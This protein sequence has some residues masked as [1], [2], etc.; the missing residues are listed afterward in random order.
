[1]FKRLLLCFVVA[2]A[3]QQ[4]FGQTIVSTTPE[5]QKVIL[6][7]FTGINC[8]FCP[9]G[10]AIAKAIQNNNPGN[11]FLINIHTGGFANP[12]AGQPDFR[13]P[14]GASIAGQSGLTGYPAGT[15]NRHYFPGQSQNG[16]TGTAMSR[17]QW[18]S[19]ANQT[20]ANA[21]YMNMAVE[22]DLDVVTNEITVHV[23]A[24]YTG[25]SPE[26]E[27]Q[28]NVALLQNNTFGPQ[29]G[30]NAGNEYEH[31]HR[32]V[33]MITGQWGEVVSPTTNG[34]FID[35][36]YTYTVPADYNDIAVDIADLE[37]VV[38]MTETN[39]E[40]ISGNGAFPTYSNFANQNDATATEIKAIDVQCGFDVAPVVTIQNTG[41]NDVTALEIEY[42]INGGT[43]STYSWT[44]NLASLQSEEVELPAIGYDVEEVNTVSVTI[45]NDDDNSNNTV[46]S[47]FDRAPIATNDITMILNTDNAGSQCTWEVVNSSGTVVESGGP[48]DN[49]SNYNV[50]MSLPGDCY[51]FTV[52]DTGGNGGG[53]IV[54]FD[55]NSVVLYQSP[56]DY[57][58]EDSA[59]FATEGFLGT[60]TNILTNVSL[61]P[62]PAN[63]AF[64]IVNAE[65]ANI[66][67]FDILGKSILSVQNISAN[68]QINVS[69]VQSGT[70]FV[71]IEKDNQTAVE[72][73]IV[74]K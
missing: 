62:N 70:Y 24:Y 63:S 14:F 45:E 4:S 56:G 5:N 6:E 54:I 36:T 55:E 73:I 74:N 53:S 57:G 51:E 8:V 2:F 26:A 44:G 18:T 15:V 12:S 41:E 46:T 72:R 34:T 11:V 49:N 30:G 28:L 43:A 40:I 13:T 59:F 20:L 32:L 35:R 47:D 3:A 23:E 22:A 69:A 71:R 66:E 50:P 19:A 7:E 61:F 37:L 17:N 65:N 27:N 29:T 58:A 16:G 48:Y 67:M 10:H 33:H 38:F 21:S 42:S 25:D 31:E 52:Y 68:Q 39:Q 9:Q 64:Q 60:E 1:M